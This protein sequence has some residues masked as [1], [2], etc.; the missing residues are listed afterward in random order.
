MESVTKNIREISIPSY[1]IF[2]SIK[3]DTKTRYGI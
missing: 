2:I 3:G 1:R